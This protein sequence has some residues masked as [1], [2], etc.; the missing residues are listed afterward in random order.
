MPADRGLLRVAG[1]A[2][3]E[4]R[5]CETVRADATGLGAAG[6]A[7]DERRHRV[8]H[9]DVRRGTR[10]A[11]TDATRQ[12]FGQRRFGC[13]AARRQPVRARH[14]SRP[15]VAPSGEKGGAM[16]PVSTPSSAS[17]APALRSRSMR[18]GAAHPPCRAA[19]RGAS[20]LGQ[21]SSRVRW[22]RGPVRRS[23]QWAQHCAVR[24]MPPLPGP[25]EWRPEHAPLQTKRPSRSRCR[26]GP[27]GRRG[28]PSR[29]AGRV[30]DGSARVERGD[31]GLDRLGERRRVEAGGGVVE[32]GED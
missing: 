18:C 21:P 26:A 3:R 28:R 17:A 15:P 30:A 9:R 5:A 19:W 16:P 8:V 22:R 11:G 27:A 4:V 13:N 12:R 29:L 1:T 23:V 6:I 20:R 10:H 7:C 24:R 31:R 14:E 32:R 2:R 25:G